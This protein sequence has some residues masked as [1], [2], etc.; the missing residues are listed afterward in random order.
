MPGKFDSEPPRTAAYVHDQ[1]RIRRQHLMRRGSQ[2]AL[3]GTAQAAGHEAVEH[4]GRTGNRLGQVLAQS[5]RSPS[6]VR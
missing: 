1:A 4:G 5:H 6:G 3:C 2:P